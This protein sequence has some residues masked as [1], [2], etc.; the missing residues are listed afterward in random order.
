MTLRDSYS[1]VEHNFIHDDAVS[2]GTRSDDFF[3]IEGNYVTINA[4]GGSDQIHF[5]SGGYNSALIYAGGGN[6]EIGAAEYCTVYGE[7]GNDTIEVG[8]KSI[9]DGGD[10]DDIFEIGSSNN[11]TLSG[12]DGN[13]TFK[14]RSTE[15]LI[16]DLENG[17][18]LRNT[19]SDSSPDYLTYTTTEDGDIILKDEDPTSFQ[20][21]LQGITD[22]SQVGD[23]QYRTENG[24]IKLGQLAEIVTEDTTPSETTTN[25]ISTQTTTDTVQAQ[26]T[27]D[28]TSE[29]DETEENSSSGNKFYTFITN[30]TNN[31]S[32]TVTTTI[33]NLFNNVVTL[34]GGV[35][36]VIENFVTGKGSS[37]DVLYLATAV[38]SFQRSNTSIILNAIDQTV[39]QINN[40][41]SVDEA[42]QYTT[43][44]EK[45]SSA[46]VGYTNES[47]KFTY[48]D[49]VTF[50]KGSTL[51]DILNVISNEGKN[52]WLN[53]S[54]GVRYSGIN[55]IDASN[56]TG[57]NTLAG[58]SNDNQI[59][60]GS[61][62]DSLWGG[63]GSSADTLIGGTGEDTFFFGKNSG[64]DVIN[65]ASSNDIVNLY[66]TT[67]S[68]IANVA[69][70]VGQIVATFKSGS[71]LT[72]N[73]TESLSS[74]FKVGGSK[75]QYNFDTSKW[76]KA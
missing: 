53:G 64:A 14:F 20:I 72:I 49:G 21:T 52:I 5:W 26:T 63:A 74:T 41:S 10:G 44:G 38:S 75:F 69:Y 62:N 2:N 13:D 51:T 4:Y 9:I 40:S 42:I 46:K 71:S 76:Q 17:D 25:T 30:I 24:S 73:N 1:G 47:N 48:E 68:D 12:G 66:G 33:T 54:R 37:S 61:G 32:N 67:L 60:A 11:V 28:T 7:D 22:I 34:A 39:L 31:I 35:S 15:M 16:T 58:D 36:Q 8:S 70:D 65:N 56:S 19:A 18:I 59:T 55:N 43:D 23:V 45:V 6:D 3:G 57:N 27:T 50:Y 29:E